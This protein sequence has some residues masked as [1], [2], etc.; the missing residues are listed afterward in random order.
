MTTNTSN[1]INPNVVCAVLTELVL[2]PFIIFMVM[3]GINVLS[4]DPTRLYLTLFCCL[5]VILDGIYLGG[6]IWDM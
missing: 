6:K 2:V 3:Y 4:N 5:V 1:K